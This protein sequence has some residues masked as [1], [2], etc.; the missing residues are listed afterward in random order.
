ML[1]TERAYERKTRSYN[2]YLWFF[3]QK[4]KE[5][6]KFLYIIWSGYILYLLYSVYAYLDGRQHVVNMDIYNAWYVKKTLLAVGI[7]AVS[8][9][10]RYFEKITLAKWVAGV[11][12]IILLV[13]VIG[14]A[15]GFF[16]YWLGFKMK[17]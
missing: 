13:P 5:N 10:C 2:Q 16:F 4:N 12:L 3:L 7:L 17:K 9:V 1:K 8:V 6:L 11:P 14:T 15:I